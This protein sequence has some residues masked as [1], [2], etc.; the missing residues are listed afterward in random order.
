MGNIQNKMNGALGTAAAALTMASHINEQAKANDIKITELEAEQAENAKELE[1]AKT[2]YENDL[3][4]AQ[5]AILANA[6]K[7]GLTE[8][9]V[10]KLKEDPAYAQDMREKLKATREAGLEEAGNAYK[11][12]YN[13][14]GEKP[15]Q[16]SDL[17]KAAYE[18]LRETNQR[19][20][21]TNKLKF[22]VESRLARQ[23][24]LAKKLNVLK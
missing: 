16:E 24:V 20:A 13:K 2:A 1:G 21:T 15:E 22:D 8:D 12:A 23:D 10:K 18:R 19:I 9:E 3:K 14:L 6:E 7:E 11:E 17:L 4:E 5:Q